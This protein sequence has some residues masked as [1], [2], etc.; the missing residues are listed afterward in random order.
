MNYMGGKH[1]Q[2][3][4]IAEKIMEVW[5]P[6]MG[7]YEPF[8]GALGAAHR[9]AGAMMA[10]GAKSP[11][12]GLSD[13]NESVI[14]MWKAVFGGWVPP[15]AVPE[16][17]YNEI[18]G[19][20]DPANPLTAYV[21]YGMSFGSKWFG[22]YARNGKGT[23]YALNAQRSVLLKASVLFKACDYREVTPSNAVMYLDPPYEGRTKAHG[24]L[25]D[26]TAFWCYA[27]AMVRNNVVL[28]TEFK[29]RTG[30]VKIHD[31]GDTVIRHHSGKTPDGTT[32]AIFV[33]ESQQ[34][35]FPLMGEP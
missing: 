14:N 6:G 11:T 18:K 17:L 10:V 12:I 30:W 16:S 25:F 22:G 29:P 35:L 3:P 31:W 7:Y 9:V 1:R 34:W 13:S 27:E 19:V 21:G 8:C 2:G 24:V 23:N 28:I 33:H 26:H 20:R 4:K 32:E 15:D 5:K